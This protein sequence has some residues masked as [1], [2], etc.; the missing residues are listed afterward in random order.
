M[1]GHSAEET[2]TE[3]SELERKISE[4]AVHEMKSISN[5]EDEL[6]ELDRAISS[7]G[8]TEEPPYTL[9]EILNRSHRERAWHKVLEY[10]LDPQNPH[11]FGS[12]ILERFLEVVERQD[13][14]FSYSVDS[15]D[16][17]EVESEVDTSEGR[18]D[19]VLTSSESWYV[20]VELKVH[21]SE[22]SSQTQRYV[23]ADRFGK[24][25]KSDFTQETYVYISKEVSGESQSDEFKDISWRS[26]VDSLEDVLTQSRGRY[27]S[28]SIAQMSGF[29]DTIKQETGMTE[30]KYEQEKRQKAKLYLQHWD[31][32]NQS[33]DA[34][35]ELNQNWSDVF[36]KE[37]KPQNWTQNWNVNNNKKGHLYKDGWRI[38]G[39][40]EPT[41]SLES[42]K[43]G[44]GIHFLHRLDNETKVKDGILVFETT[45]PYSSDIREKFIKWFEEEGRSKVESALPQLEI[46]QKR[47]VF[48]HME[49]EFD[50]KEFPDSYFTTLVEAFED[51][52]EVSDVISEGLEKSLE[53]QL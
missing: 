29:I 14:E 45:S 33:G 48:T 38:D 19:M 13:P 18:V 41:S 7:I 36:L 3:L 17:V 53:K 23:E 2:K 47:S 15:L 1:E 30:N 37:H 8:E 10:F 20:C 16:E 28:R 52:Q 42:A 26:V 40:L 31:A 27:P 4:V 24:L 21:S 6:A 32:I 11:G 43:D 50:I 25:S 9:L 44:M 51:H 49:Y 34:F 35:E 12:E 46:P 5:I 39:N 22:G